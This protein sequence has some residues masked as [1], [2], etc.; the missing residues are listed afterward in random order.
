MGAVL[1]MNAL[2]LR[3]GATLRICKLL[4]SHGYPS[5][6]TRQCE[7]WHPSGTLAAGRPQT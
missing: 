3:M 1:R 2:L 6:T 5:A 7:V 4:H